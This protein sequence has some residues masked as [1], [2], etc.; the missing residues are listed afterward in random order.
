MKLSQVKEGQR[1]VLSRNGEEYKH[2]GMHPSDKH[3]VLVA[4]YKSN[5]LENEMLYIAC[6]VEVVS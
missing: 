2:Y 1:F 6:E 5:P 3:Y 4:P